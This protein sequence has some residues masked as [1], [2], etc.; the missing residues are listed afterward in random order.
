[1]SRRRFVGEPDRIKATA[2]PMPGGG[3]NVNITCTDCGEPIDHA[4]E[5]GMY[6]KNECGIEED[7][8]AYQRLMGAF[9]S[10]FRGLGL[11]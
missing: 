4:N 7:K 6:C 9:G 11:G 3:V 8:T 1:M 5:Y 10:I 2:E